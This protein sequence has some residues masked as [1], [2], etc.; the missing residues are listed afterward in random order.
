[1]ADAVK[2]IEELQRKTLDKDVPEGSE[3]LKR[4]SQK[5]P[6]SRGLCRRCGENKPVNRLMLCYPCWVK[7]NLEERGWREGQ[8]HPEWCECT[9]GDHGRRS[10]GN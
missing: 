8:S 2:Q 10:D 5:E 4:L 7:T 3:D 9:L 6:P 1:M